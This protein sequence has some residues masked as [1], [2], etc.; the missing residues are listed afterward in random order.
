MR[1]GGEDLLEYKA[2]PEG[3]RGIP[4]SVKLLEFHLDST[5]EERALYARELRRRH[6]CLIDPV[7][8]ARHGREHAW[9][10]DLHV[11]KEAEWIARPVAETATTRYNAHLN[12]TLFSCQRGA[13]CELS[14]WN[15][16]R[17]YGLVANS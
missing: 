14:N 12:H 11:L 16:R 17:K 5:A 1:A 15:V 3:V 6:T 9:L 8:D 13:C 4:R 7:Q 2:I 10:E